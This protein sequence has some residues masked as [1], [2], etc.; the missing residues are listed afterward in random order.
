MLGGVV[1]VCLSGVL[2][3]LLEWSYKWE[4]GKGCEGWRGW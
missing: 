4:G 1:G 2:A 3:K